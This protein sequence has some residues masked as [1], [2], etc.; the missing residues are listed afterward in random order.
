MVGGPVT[1][2]R[3]TTPEGLEK[4][5]KHEAWKLGVSLVRVA[6]KAAEHGRTRAQMIARQSGMRATGTYERSFIIEDTANGAILANTAKH[7]YF[8]ERGR[9]AGKAPPAAVILRW[10]MDKGSIKRIPVGNGR[11]GLAKTPKHMKGRARRIFVGVVKEVASQRRTSKREQ[12][13]A[14][15]WSRAFNIARAIGKRGIRGRFILGR[16]LPAI[17]G[18][19]RS[20]LT[21]IKRG[22]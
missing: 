11:A 8:V 6:R 10:L 16:A 18:F 4:A 1:A 20:E 5:L 17:K 21:K 2:R 19:I 14:E 7:A 3:R 22:V 15:C 9:R 12:Y 13:V